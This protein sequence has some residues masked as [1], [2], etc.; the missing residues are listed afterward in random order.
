MSDDHHL[1]TAI[2]KPQYHCS[3]AVCCP[4][5]KGDRHTS[6]SAKTR[7]TA[8]LVR[9]PLST[10]PHRRT[11]EMKEGKT[12]D[13]SELR[14]RTIRFFAR[15]GKELEQIRQLL[16]V[17]LSQLALAHTI[18]NNLPREAVLISTRVKTLKSFLA[19]LEKKN[20][21]TFYYPTEV[22]QDLI[23][24]RIVCWFIDD[25][26]GMLSLIETSS[27]L[28]VKDEVKDYMANPK[29][30]GYRSIHLLADVTYDGILRDND[31]VTTSNKAMVCEIQIRTKLQDA[32][33]DVT[34]EF[35]YRA[36]AAGID[37]G[38]YE[39]LLSEIA[40]RLANE[41]ESLLT[42]RNA[43]RKLADEKMKNQIR[44]GL[45]KE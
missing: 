2:G 37:N 14:D 32:W 29:K 31:R 3:S 27:H 11:N 15:Y 13:P 39:R 24:A 30:S 45:R 12:R 38:L 36:K 6:I 10:I 42:L 21:P 8:Q 41:D 9:P 43:Y 44:E 5:Q 4:P 17:R 33:G 23:G 16:S 18:S 26:A 35:H 34:H 28:K 20:W 40:T 1:C 25:C 22:I 19:K 7:H